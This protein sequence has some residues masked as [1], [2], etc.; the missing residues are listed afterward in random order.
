MDS[1]DIIKMK[2]R[3]KKR[4]IGR[5]F[6]IGLIVLIC[7]SNISAF[8]ISSDYWSGYPLKMYPSQS[9]NVSFV[10]ENL[11]STSNLNLRAVITAGSDIL[12]ASDSSSTYNV[13]AG[14]EGVANFVAT[15][16]ADAKP[17]QVYPV[18]IDF[19]EVK[20]SASGEFGF[21]TA[22][23]QSFD[24]IAISPSAPQPTG[25]STTLIFC[26]IAGIVV[27]AVIIF[28]ILRKTKKRKSHGKKRK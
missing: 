26:I 24:V 23:G 8:A 14:Q 21:G 28:V 25:M 4:I 12:R 15:L 10:L 22:I 1:A 7:I 17:G 11:D 19:T 9:Q 6:L 20:N 3:N 18:T 16:P 2:I 13:L 5:E 27:L